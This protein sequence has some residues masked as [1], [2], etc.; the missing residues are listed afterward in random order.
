[1]TRHELAFKQLEQVCRLTVL[2]GMTN[3]MRDVFPEG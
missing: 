2:I 1:M 3:D